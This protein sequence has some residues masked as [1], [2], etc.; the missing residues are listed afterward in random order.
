MCLENFL[1]W[2]KSSG[3]EDDVIFKIYKIYIGLVGWFS[4]Y[5]ISLLVWVLFWN[6]YKGGRKELI[7]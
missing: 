4:R 5:Y 2:N 1:E 6:L 3:F 7:R